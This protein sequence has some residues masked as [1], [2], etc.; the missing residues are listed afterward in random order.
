MAVRISFCFQSLSSLVTTRF[1]EWEWDGHFLYIM[2]GGTQGY[3]LSI[4]TY[5][6]GILQFIKKL[7]AEFTVVTQP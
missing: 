1:V 4:F 2:E 6:I 5:V 7:K 3:P